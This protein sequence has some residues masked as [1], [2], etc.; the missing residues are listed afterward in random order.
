M[1]H[2]PG[3]CRDKKLRR[4]LEYLSTMPP[5]V[6]QRL[7]EEWMWELD[8]LWRKEGIPEDLKETLD[9]PEKGFEE[10][11]ADIDDPA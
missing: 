3:T 6:V 7:L 9:Q 2:S 5:E 4:I 1:S 11:N 10:T 8:E